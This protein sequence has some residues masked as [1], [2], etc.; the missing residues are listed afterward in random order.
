M[1]RVRA[2]APRAAAGIRPAIPYTSADDAGNRRR[3]GATR[4]LRQ[5]GTQEACPGG[6]GAARRAE[7]RAL[8]QE[9][10]LLGDLRELL[11]AAA[12]PEERLVVLRQAIADLDQLFLLVIVG[13]FNAGKSA[14]VNALLGATVLEEG[15]TPTTAAVTVLSHADDPTSRVDPDGIVR[16][17]QPVP[18]LCATSGLVDTPG[19]NAILRHHE[20]LTREFIPRSDLVLFVTSA[21]R[22]FTE[23]ERAFLESI[24]AWG[25]K[26]VVVLNKVDL[27]QLPGRADHTA[28]V[29]RGERRSLARLRAEIFPISARHA[30]AAQEQP[31]P[32]ERQRLRQ[33]SGF[34]ALEA[35]LHD[36][37]D[38]AGRLRLKLLSP[39][40]VA[41]RL[42]AEQHEAAAAR[43][44]ILREDLRAGE[45]IDRQLELFRDDMRRDLEPR[46][47]EL[48][49]VTR[50]MG[51]RGELFFDETLRI[52][53]VFDLF[54]S[55]RIRGEFE[56]VVIADTPE[57]IDR[58]SQELID[59]M[60]DQDLRLWKSVAE[61]L[62]ERG[63]QARGEPSGR[64]AGSFEYDRRTLLQS[65]GRVAR[66]VLQRHDHRREAQEL[67]TS[68][69]ETVTRATAFQAGAVSLG[70]VTAA[71]AS[72]VA[73]DVT[74]LLAAGVMAGIGFYILPLKKRR[75]LE[76]FR[77]RTDELREGL[78]SAL[79]SEFERELDASLRRIRDALAP[80]D[81]FVR[82][83]QDR[84]GGTER[85]L[86][87]LQ[88][89][90][91]LLRG[92]IELLGPTIA[93]RGPD[94]EPAGPT[95][96]HSVQ[97]ES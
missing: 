71:V 1:E 87:G 74:G 23:S 8:A 35:A 83:E 68:V 94:Q 75:A 80:Y 5:H 79:R 44:E 97:T 85:A 7:I 69:R 55:D 47:G 29:H 61:Q 13:E 56:R 19:T 58:L 88:E 84:I 49:N 59:W 48:E 51:E 96:T 54:N 3:P 91:R 18:L 52:G 62:D 38:D 81:R 30:R 20:R 16:I 24:R 37:L 50:A 15:V 11:A 14:F 21:D 22:P 76:Q 25:K 27:L 60:V 41:D 73:A 64:L 10:G 43:L 31:D 92:N 42:A 9:R 12:V 72:T 90:L 65:V 53:R 86:S 34:D 26:V 6:S 77:T 33:S 66:D 28:S 39:L 89:R 2:T 40:G 32:A 93:E 45:S 82:A 36:T 78:T 57:Q 4:T 46:L 95:P 63:R 17:G 67:A 70:A